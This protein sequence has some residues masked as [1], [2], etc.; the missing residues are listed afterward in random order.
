[1]PAPVAVRLA[2]VG[3]AIEPILNRVALVGA[4]AA[5]LL[6]SDPSV[7]IPQMNFAA[8]SVLQ[9]LSTS[10]VDR[11]G[12]DIQKLGFARIGRTERADRWRHDDGITLDLVQ[13]QTDGRTPYELCLEYATLLTWTV[14]FG[15]VA[16]RVAT[17]PALLALECASFA[18]G[19]TRALESEELERAILLI[20]GCAGIE[21]ECAAAPPELRSIIASSLAQLAATDALSLLLRRALPDA[22]VLPAFAARVRDRIARMGC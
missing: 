1:M 17:A 19:G 5:A 10:M 14:A 22:A 4:P 9:L 16:M 2:R 8:D 13:V 11:L 15:S 18:A 20:A 21:T 3:R 12:L 7:R 6:T